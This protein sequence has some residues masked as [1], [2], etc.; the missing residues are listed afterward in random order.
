MIVDV[1]FWM[2]RGGGN[3]QARAGEKQLV[4]IKKTTPSG[5]KKKHKPVRATKNKTLQGKQKPSGQRK[6][7]LSLRVLF[8]V[9]SAE[10]LIK[11]KKTA[12]I[13]KQQRQFVFP[14]V[15]ADF[16]YK[17]RSFER[18]RFLVVDWNNT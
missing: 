16:L 4:G 15:S 3:G 8:V 1:T 14:L 10:T 9:A 6:K 5:N 12:E 11:Q 13:L 2:I 17:P 7:S 18:S